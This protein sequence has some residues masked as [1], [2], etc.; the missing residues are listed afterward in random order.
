MFPKLSETFILNQITGLLRRGHSVRIFSRYRPEERVFHPEVAEYD[1]LSRTVYLPA[2]P[3]SKWGCR[4]KA[5][6]WLLRFL[7]AHPIVTVR[8]LTYLLGREE[9][10]SYLL[11]FHSLPILSFRPDVIMVHF[12]NN[13]T[14]YWPLKEMESRGAFLTMFHGHDLLLGLEN[15]PEYYRGLFSK[16]DLILANS[17]FTRERLLEQG[18]CPER[19]QVH[20]VGIEPAR[21]SS[22]RG[23]AERSVGPFR[24]LTICRLCEQKRPDVALCAV[25][26]LKE[27]VHPAAVEYHLVGDGPMRPDLER[28]AEHLDI[29]KVVVFEGA[30][31]QKGV[32]EQLRLA[33]VFLLTSR[34]E[35]LGV[36]LLEAQAAGVPIV[37]TNV[38]GIPEAVLAGK[39]AILVPPGDVE[40]AAAA[41]A[42][43]LKDPER[44]VRMGQE[45][46]KYVEENF[47]IEVLNDRLEKMFFELVR[48]CRGRMR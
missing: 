41:M 43:L 11:F 19:L 27:L 16:A 32:L 14:Y 4:L 37:A 46:R 31:E 35:W 18:A 26:R 5:V 1:L 7:I 30:L 48:Q 28:L 24:V 33:D 39:S 20:Y 3:A 23:P 42:E 15:G 22:S 25:R 29:G 13:G 8:V 10:F 21:F 36:V 44:R 9:P 47:D 34:D 45:G 12:G 2:V 38:G 17:E 40:A 6:F